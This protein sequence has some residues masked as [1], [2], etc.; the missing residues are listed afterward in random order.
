MKIIASFL[1]LAFLVQAQVTRA[2]FKPPKNS[3]PAPASFYSYWKLTP[4]LKWSPWSTLVVDAPLVLYRDATGQG[5]IALNLPVQVSG[6]SIGNL[7]GLN[8]IAGTGIIP[9]DQIGSNGFLNLQDNIDSTVVQTIPVPGCVGCNTFLTVTL[10]P[11]PTMPVIVTCMF[12]SSTTQI[13]VNCNAPG[14]IQVTAYPLPISGPIGTSGTYG[15]GSQIVT[16][17]FTPFNG[18]NA[19]AICPTSTSTGTCWQVF[20]NGAS[21]S[22]SF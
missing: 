18:T 8:F 12:L 1:T 20:S 13:M 6:T 2:P 14:S 9:N 7:T 17:N 10:P 22:G 16:W 19:I 4:D 5:H 11:P 15:Q 21:Q 3:A